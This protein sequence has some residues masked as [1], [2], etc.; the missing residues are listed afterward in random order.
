M[1]GTILSRIRSRTIADIIDNRAGG[2]LPAPI[3]KERS[4]PIVLIG[5][6]FG[7]QYRK[8]KLSETRK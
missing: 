4:L 6:E 3:K 2:S 5:S 1:S 7:V 8:E